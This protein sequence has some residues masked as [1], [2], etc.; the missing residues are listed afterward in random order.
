[1]DFICFSKK[2]SIFIHSIFIFFLRIV[3]MKRSHDS[4]FGKMP[5][6]CV[7]LFISRF[8]LS[9][10]LNVLI[11]G[12][13]QCPCNI[14]KKSPIEKAAQN[15]IEVLKT[16]DSISALKKTKS[17]LSHPPLRNIKWIIYHPILFSIGR[18]GQANTMG[19]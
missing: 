4:M 13:S 19:S 9:M 14:S 15:N 16:A 5:I 10:Q 17:S 8:K 18:D 7:H 11:L 6:F 1:M 3:P 12:N 2:K